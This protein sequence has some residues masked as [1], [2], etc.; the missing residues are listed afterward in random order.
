MTEGTKTGNR[1]T[2]RKKKTNIA[3]AFNEYFASIGTEMAD[4]LP[5]MDGY[6]TYLKTTPAEFFFQRVTGGG[7]SI[8]HEKATA[9]IIDWS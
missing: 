2:I 4:S 3:K 9:K 8:N 6:E 7:S 1:Q 5:N